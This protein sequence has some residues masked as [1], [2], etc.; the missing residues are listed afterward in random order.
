MAETKK[1]RERIED[2]EDR[3]L[4]R[5]AEIVLV[6]E[7]MGQMRGGKDPTDFERGLAVEARHKLVEICASSAKPN[8]LFSTDSARVLAADLGFSSVKDRMGNRPTKKI[9]IVE[10]LAITKK[11]VNELLNKMA[12]RIENFLFVFPFLSL[13]QSFIHSSI[14]FIFVD[15]R[16]EGIY[17]T[18]DSTAKS[19]STGGDVIQAGK[20][21]FFYTRIK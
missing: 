1:K 17:T 8:D 16:N 6:L 20:S 4:K 2:G 9:S 7:A 19:F 12:E 10:K 14:R 15:A 3:D 5:V 18:T 11:K 21:W 13:N